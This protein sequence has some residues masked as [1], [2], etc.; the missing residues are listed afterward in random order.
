[1]NIAGQHPVFNLPRLQA[2][3]LWAVCEGACPK[4]TLLARSRTEVF[5]KETGKR[6]MDFVPS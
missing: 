1:M 2:A 3:S 4:E 5:L 6:I